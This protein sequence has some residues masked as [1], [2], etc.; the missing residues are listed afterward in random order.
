MD[1]W[2]SVEIRLV[3]ASFADLQFAENVCRI[4]GVGKKR[5]N[6]ICHYGFS[7]TARAGD[8]DIIGAFFYEW[9]QFFE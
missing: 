7:E 6:H 3:A 4:M 1:H 2:I 5:C 9:E 8:T